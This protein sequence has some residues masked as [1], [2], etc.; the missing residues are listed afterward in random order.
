M[1][2]PGGTSQETIHI[3]LNIFSFRTEGRRI[4]A[5]RPQLSR[6]KAAGKLPTLTCM[7]KSEAEVFVFVLS[8]FVSVWFLLFKAIN[9]AYI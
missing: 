1:K 9:S 5:I 8:I 4:F 6:A 3:F 7:A 2:S